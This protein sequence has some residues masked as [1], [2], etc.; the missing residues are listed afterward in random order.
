[1]GQLRE[2]VGLGV[3]ASFSFRFREGVCRKAILIRRKFI[4]IT[5]S[6]CILREYKI[7]FSGMHYAFTTVLKEPLKRHVD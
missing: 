7:F 2:Q 4:C 1:M 6:N 5:D 3:A